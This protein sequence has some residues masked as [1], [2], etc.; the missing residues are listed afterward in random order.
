MRNSD[1]ELRASGKIWEK[2]GRRHDQLPGTSEPQPLPLGRRAGFCL[3]RFRDQDL[4]QALI[5]LCNIP[6]CPDGCRG[7]C[8][9]K[10]PLLATLGI[11]LHPGPPSLQPGR[12]SFCPTLQSHKTGKNDVLEPLPVL[13][14]ECFQTLYP[15]WFVLIL[16][17]QTP[18]TYTH[19][20]PQS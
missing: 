14:V 7:C 1:W 19:P 12:F 2:A 15:L 3:G 11:A 8:G 13:T 17:P 10:R 6:K 20:A 9:S 5:S 18:N 16:L 4:Q